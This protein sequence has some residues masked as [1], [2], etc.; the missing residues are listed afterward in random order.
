MYLAA[1]AVDVNQNKTNY[2]LK[3][4]S[5]QAEQPGF[6]EIQFHQGIEELKPKNGVVV[7]FKTPNFTNISPGKILTNST[8][9]HMKMKLRQMQIRCNKR[10]VCNLFRFDAIAQINVLIFALKTPSKSPENHEISL[11]TQ[12]EQ[13]GCFQCKNK[14]FYLGYSVETK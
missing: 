6:Y 5:F 14:H 8:F 12:Y 10:E 4:A 7:I 3:F 13:K 1:V 9:I 11:K 2:T